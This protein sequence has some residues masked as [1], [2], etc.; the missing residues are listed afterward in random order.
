LS[1]VPARLRYYVVDAI[2]EWRHSPGPNVLAVATLAAVLF[3]AGTNLLVLANVSSRVGRWKDDLRVSI[4]LND[5][6][7]ASDVD[8]LDAK[9]A[10][11]P[12]VAKVIRVDKDE[13]LRRFQATFRDLADVPSELG[14][15]P[16]PASLE[17]VLDPGPRA[18]DTAHLVGAAATGAPP[19]EEVRYDQAV[20]D[21]IDAILDVAR[22]GGASLGLVVFTAVAFVV[23]GVLR[24]TVHARRD[25]IEIMRLVGAPPMMVRGPFLVAGLAQG[26]AG[27]ACALFL[28]EAARRAL[29]AYAG[30]S[31]AELLDMVAG[32][33]LPIQPA[34]LIVGVGASLGIASAWVAV[35]DASRSAA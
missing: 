34:L 14:K 33:A 16:L 20:L 22:W 6:A 18:R 30:P 3:V 10:A 15:N 21:R 31:P 12:G 32:S 4:Y 27:S 19:V 5:D 17:V 13:A 24:L 1:L 9:V 25:E 23:A 2:D 11:L 28:V 29:H 7:S 8:A 26:L 35:R